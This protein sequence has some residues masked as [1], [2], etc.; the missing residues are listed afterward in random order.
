MTNEVIINTNKFKKIHITIQYVFR[1]NFNDTYWL[2]EIEI[3]LDELNKEKLQWFD[4]YNKRSKINNTLVAI[5]YVSNDNFIIYE[6]K[7][8]KIIEHDTI[9]YSDCIIVEDYDNSKLLAAHLRVK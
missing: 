9:N 8:D 1:A 6:K 4:P 3:N 2:E 5:K 7:D